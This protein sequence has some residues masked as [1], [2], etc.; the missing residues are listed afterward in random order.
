[1]DFEDWIQEVYFIASEVD[2]RIAAS[3]AEFTFMY[4]DYFESGMTPHEA[5]EAEWGS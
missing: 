1:M 4:E 2:Y 5:Y 3:I